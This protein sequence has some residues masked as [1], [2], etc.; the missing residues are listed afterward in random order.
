MS[1]AEKKGQIQP[2]V[3]SNVPRFSLYTYIPIGS[4]YGIFTYIYNEYQPFMREIYQSHGSY[5]IYK[6]W[7]LP[8]VFM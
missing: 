5:G 4:M 6:S 8:P 1:C 3:T 2:L 7:N